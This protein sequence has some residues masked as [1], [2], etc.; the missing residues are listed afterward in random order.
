MGS[1]PRR[2]FPAWLSGPGVSTHSSSSG[3]PP[4]APASALETASEEH[5]GPEAPPRPRCAP[6]KCQ[7]VYNRPSQGPSPR[8]RQA[9]HPHGDSRPGRALTAQEAGLVEAAA[10]ALDLFSKVHRL[11][12]HPTLLASSPV[13]HPA[14]GHREGNELSREVDTWMAQDRAWGRGLPSRQPGGFPPWSPQGT[15]AQP[16]YF[17]RLSPLHPPAL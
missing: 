11:L 7:A 12:A 10:F 3:Q 5:R 15:A 8:A 13:R 9:G 1:F 17:Q 6:A 16:L 14:S 2:V 4:T